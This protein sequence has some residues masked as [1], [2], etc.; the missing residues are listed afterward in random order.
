[1]KRLVAAVLIAGAICVVPRSSMGST[2]VIPDVTKAYERARA[3]FLGE[4]IGI[5]EPRS[6]GLSHSHPASAGCQA[7]R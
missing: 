3:V 6:F 7:G 5:V 4:V 2:C 1:M